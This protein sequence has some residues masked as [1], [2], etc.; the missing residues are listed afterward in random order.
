MKNIPQLKFLEEEEKLLKE[1]LNKKKFEYFSGLCVNFNNLSSKLFSSDSTVKIARKIKN[2]YNLD[3]LNPFF[4]I[5]SNYG[6][7]FYTYIYKLRN[8]FKALSYNLNDRNFL[9]SVIIIRSILETT[10]CFLFYNKEIEKKVMKFKKIGNPSDQ[11]FLLLF[12][13]I[14]DILSKSHNNTSWD[15]TE[16]FGEKFK[17]IDYKKLNINDPLRFTEKFTGKRFN[18][19]YSLLSE[20]THPNFGSNTLV[21][22]TIGEEKTREIHDIILGEGKHDNCFLWFF[23]NFS[24]ALCETLYLGFF[25]CESGD[26]YYRYFMNLT[27]LYYETSSKDFKIH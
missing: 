8:Y 4:I 1:K 18:Y 26:E 24:E 2:P 10:C 11:D 13:H 6:N 20:M 17:P 3:S 12:K 25:V 21:R 19:Y 9:V 7:F 27:D 14:S 15:W 5:E 23:D 16:Q 22:E